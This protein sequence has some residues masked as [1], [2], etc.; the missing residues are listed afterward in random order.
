METP[1]LKLVAAN[2]DALDS[3]AEDDDREPTK[4]EILEDLRIALRDV[5][6]GYAGQDAREMLK[7]LRQEIYG[8]ANHT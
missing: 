1:K 2:E 3:V 8:D 5:R 6:A 4:E 7:E